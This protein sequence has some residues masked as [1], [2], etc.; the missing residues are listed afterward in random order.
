MSLSLSRSRPPGSA[1]RTYCRRLQPERQRDLVVRAEK[2]FPPLLALAAAGD[3]EEELQALVLPALDDVEVAGIVLDQRLHQRAGEADVARL[4]TNAGA[5]IQRREQIPAF[6]GA[7]GEHRERSGPGGPLGHE[8]SLHDD[9]EGV[10]QLQHVAEEPARRARR[11]PGGEPVPLGDA[12]ALPHLGVHLEM[13]LL[14]GE[15]EQKALLQ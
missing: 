10:L 12:R 11:F 7:V 4:V 8:V 6:L 5:M 1:S 14:V 15:L 13:A 2:A 9:L 3:L